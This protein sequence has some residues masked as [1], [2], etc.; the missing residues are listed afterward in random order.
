MKFSQFKLILAFSAIGCLFPSCSS[1]SEDALADNTDEFFVASVETV[2]F[3]ASTSPEGVSAVRIE[4]ETTTLKIQGVSNE[5]NTI[6]LLVNGYEGS[7]TYNLGFTNNVRGNYGRYSDQT[8]EWNS[9]GAALGL[10]SVTIN[11]INNGTEI[12]GTFRFV[13]FEAHYSGSSR[14]VIDGEFRAKFEEL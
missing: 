2:P 12:T 11:V 5:G 9:V 6:V 10:G 7:R 1:S 13:G 14:T 4:N 3:T 8:R